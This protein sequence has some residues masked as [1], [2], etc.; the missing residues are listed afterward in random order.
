MRFTHF[1]G[2]H[3]FGLGFTDANAAD[4]IAVKMQPHQSLGASLAQVTVGSA[5][6][7][8]EDLL[9]RSARLFPAFPSPSDSPFNGTAQFARRAGAGGAI[10]K[11]HR[12]FP[13]KFAL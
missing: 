7:D 1:E 13:N 10:T 4:S 12:H 8:A 9:A 5:L 11:T 3:H 6:H 2:A